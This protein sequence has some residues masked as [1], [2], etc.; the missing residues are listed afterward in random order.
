MINPFTPERNLAG[1]PSL[2]PDSG[3]PLVF[4]ADLPAD[5]LLPRLIDVRPVDAG[6]WTACCPAHADDMPSLSI[7]ETDDFKLL[8][9]CHAGCNISDVMGAVGLNTSNLFA[10]DYAKFKA[11]QTGKRKNLAA[12]TARPHKTVELSVP[13]RLIE[14]LTAH[15]KA[16]HAAA[17]NGGHCENLARELLLPVQAL[18]DFG[19]G[20]HAFRNRTVYSFVERDGK[21]RVIGI[22]Y[23]DSVDASKACHLESRRGLIYS[24][25]APAALGD[26]SAP[27]YIPEGHTDTIALHGCGCLTVGRSAAKLSVAA[28]H[29]LAEYLQARPELWQSRPVVVVGDNDDAGV[30][31]ARETAMMLASAINKFVTI[32]FPPEQYKDMRAWITRGDFVPGWPINLINKV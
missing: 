22:L 4:A 28:E 3:G 11:V 20:W 31:G 14:A 8:V 19:V 7:R 27:L 13:A 29:W 9:Y 32:A 26:P 16:C 1:H 2:P 30:S 5:I 25:V 21:G 23:R 24:D 6:Q 18:S 12:S 10:S 15:T 17:V